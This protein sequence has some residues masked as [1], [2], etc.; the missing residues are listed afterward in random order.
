MK[1]TKLTRWHPAFPYEVPRDLT[2]KLPSGL[3]YAGAGRMV[4]VGPQRPRQSFRLEDWGE[5][6]ASQARALLLVAAVQC[7]YQ[8]HDL[9][10]VGRL[11]TRRPQFV[12][13]HPGQRVEVSSGESRTGELW[14][15]PIRPLLGPPQP[16]H[17]DT[18]DGP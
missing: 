9:P 2:M 17:K 4:L 16:T 1:R 8:A 5:A 11:L 14:A 7:H 12:H 6:I 10:A 13:I 18:H 3:T 15:F